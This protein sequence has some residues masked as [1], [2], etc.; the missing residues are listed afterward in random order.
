MNALA[1]IAFLVLFA[2]ALRPASGAEPPYAPRVRTG[3]LGK[4]ERLS[5]ALDNL[6]APDAT[7]EI[8]ADGFDWAEGPVWF[9]PG[10]YLLFS[11]VP[12]NVVWRWRENDGL[13]EYLRPSG[14]TGSAIAPEESGSNGLTLDNDGRLILCQHGDR[15]VARIK[16]RGKFEPLATNFEGKRFNSPNDVAIRSNGELYFTDPP[17]GL[18]K[19]ADDP[20]RELPYQGVFRISQRGRVT[21]LVRDLTRPN[22][23]AFSPDEKRLYVAVSDPQRAHYMVYDVQRDGTLGTGKVFFDAT[24]LV[25]GRKG[26]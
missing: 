10:G 23:I 22:G 18:V 7:V 13:L 5:P 24:P 17:Y 2:A 1:S 15:Q 21:L 12:R 20:A 11:D 25:P 14:Y 26:L 6:L 19:G 8:L 16:G 4:I 9:A 3:T